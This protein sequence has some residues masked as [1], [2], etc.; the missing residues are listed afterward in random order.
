[1]QRPAV[2]ATREL[3]VPLARLGQRRLPQHAHHGVI[4]GPEALQ[5]IEELAGQLHRRHPAQT[6]QPP[7]LGEG[8]KG[9]VGH[10]QRNGWRGHVCSLRSWR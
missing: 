4:G 9:D 5:P 8:E 2:L 10:A 1:M 3:R 7:E 6:E